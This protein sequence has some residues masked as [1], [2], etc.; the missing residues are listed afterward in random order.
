L[1]DK[2]RVSRVIPGG[3]FLFLERRENKLNKHTH[4]SKLLMLIP[5]L[6]TGI[7]I[8]NAEPLNLELNQKL[9][10]CQRI[11]TGSARLTCYDALAQSL[12][13]NDVVA[14][15]AAEMFGQDEKKY[16]ERLEAS[17]GYKETN[18]LQAR[19]TDITRNAYGQFIVTLENGQVWRQ[20]DSRRLRINVGDT[21]TIMKGRFGT[22]QLKKSSGT[23]TLRV[24]RVSLVQQSK[25]LLISFSLKRSVGI[26]FGQ[27]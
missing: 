5:V 25:L 6:L 4:L 8:S 17:T 12:V 26:L 2:I 9:S 3:P 20:F 13:K 24:R 11:N 18:S 16:R 1:L 7:Q 19:V 21:V 10:E 14:D 22:F 27:T 15:T 23:V